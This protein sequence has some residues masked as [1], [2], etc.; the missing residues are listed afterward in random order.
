MVLPAR[1]MK[2]QNECSCWR[3]GQCSAPY[4][5]GL[6][7]VWWGNSSKHPIELTPETWVRNRPAVDGLEYEYVYV[8]DRHCM[9]WAEWS[10]WSGQLLTLN[11]ILYDCASV[12]V[13]VFQCKLGLR[14]AR[15]ECFRSALYV[16]LRDEAYRPD[17]ER[18]FFFNECCLSLC[19]AWN[20]LEDH[21]L[22]L[23]HFLLPLWHTHFSFSNYE[24][25]MNCIIQIQ[26]WG[27]LWILSRVVCFCMK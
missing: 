3:F 10:D 22:I 20:T 8:L 25:D 21:P 19:R 26:L 15:L 23:F 11:L 17:L 12:G 9:S 16:W 14:V 4:G 1:G 5:A 13:R 2:E 18:F 7:R 27:K 24:K 6:G